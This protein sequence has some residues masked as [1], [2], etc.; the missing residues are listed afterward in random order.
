MKATRKSR[1]KSFTT[2]NLSMKSMIRSHRCHLIRRFQKSSTRRIR[3]NGYL[4][5]GE[6]TSNHWIKVDSKTSLRSIHRLTSQMSVSSVREVGKST[7]RNTC[8]RYATTIDHKMTELKSSV[9]R[10]A[11]LVR[12]A[13]R[14]RSWLS[15]IFQESR[16]SS[17]F[18]VVT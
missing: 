6:S 17:A 15:L 4:Q 14:S 1:H 18:A 9:M 13:S 11:L 2:Q 8:A 16:P 5:R 3:M 10:N 12:A 7:N